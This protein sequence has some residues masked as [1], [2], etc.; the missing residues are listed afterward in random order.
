MEKILTAFC[1]T[2]IH[3]QQAM[4][5][6]P[7][8]LRTSLIKAKELAMKEFGGADIALV[9]GDNISDYPHWER[10]CALPK[11]NFLIIS[12]SAFP[13][14][15]SK[16]FTKIRKNEDKKRKAPCLKQGAFLLSFL[17]FNIILKKKFL[18]LFASV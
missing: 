11:K 2:D 18:F 17:F 15:E 6:Y 8:K 3:N 1:Y 9:G 7:T 16:W 5:D 4:L 10:S 14:K 12:T 13:L